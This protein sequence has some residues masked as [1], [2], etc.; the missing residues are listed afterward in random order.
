MYRNVIHDSN[1]RFVASTL[2]QVFYFVAACVYRQIWY[3]IERDEGGNG[4]DMFGRLR[5]VSHTR[6]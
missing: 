2:Q 3:Y 5:T 6:R 1:Y 4:I